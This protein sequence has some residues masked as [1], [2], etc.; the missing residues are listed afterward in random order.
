M[1]IYVGKLGAQED[2]LIYFVNAQDFG[3]LCAGGLSDAHC[4]LS[5]TRGA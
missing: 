2:T 4:L 5:S 3:R 1:N